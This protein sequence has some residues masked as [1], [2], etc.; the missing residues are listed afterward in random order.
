MEHSIPDDDF[1]RPAK[2]DRDK[3]VF[4][5]RWWEATDRHKLYYIGPT[6]FQIPIAR[7]DWRKPGWPDRP[8]P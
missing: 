6:A 8:H 5:V 2:T 3:K 7:E 4:S 1:V